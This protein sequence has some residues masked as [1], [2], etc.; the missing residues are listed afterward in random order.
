MPD[1]DFSDTRIFSIAFKVV[2]A[3][4]IILVIMAGPVSFVFGT[5]L[6]F[7]PMYQVIPYVEALA[8]LDAEH[9]LGITKVCDKVT[10]GSNNTC[11]FTTTNIDLFNDTIAIYDFR[12]IMLSPYPGAPVVHSAIN[13]AYNSQFAIVS[14]TNSSGLTTCA[15]G[16]IPIPTA[17]QAICNVGHGDRV[18]VH[19]T[20]FK[21]NAKGTFP[22]S[23][24]VEWVDLCDAPNTQACDPVNHAVSAAG[25]ATTVI[26]PSVSIVKTASPTK[27]TAGTNVTYTYKVTNTGNIR[28]NNCAVTDNV[29]GPIGS[30]QSP[31]APGA[32]ATLN[33]TAIVSANVT[34]TGTVTCNHQLGQVSNSSSATVRVIHPAI[35]VVKTCDSV[36]PQAPG[37]ITWH[38]NVTNIGDVSLTVTLND[39]SSHTFP[40]PFSLI[41]GERRSFNFTDSNLAAGTY[42]D[43]VTAVG[44]YQLGEVS[45]TDTASCVISNTTTTTI[46]TKTADRTTAKPGD[47]I[48]YTVTEHNNGPAAISNVT[49]IDSFNGTLTVAS[50][51]SNNPGIL[52]SGETWTFQTYTRHVTQ[53]DCNKTLHN[54]VTAT[55]TMIGDGP[56]PKETAQFDVSVVCPPIGGEILGTNTSALLVAAVLSNAM[57]M[58]PTLVGVAGAAILTALGLR[59]RNSE[60]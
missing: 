4:A 54:N 14:I 13:P 21:M 41:P 37:T 35:D 51:D 56:A 6:V 1:N 8:P 12:D 25:S 60:D 11:F 15:V 53:L 24:E 19:E 43:T 17:G 40:P 20:S 9:G 7:S 50:G 39:T 57:W 59:R 18:R 38:V 42:N 23:A 26:S 36:T 5:P 33:K 30:T 32:S 55:G 27:V 44:K 29:Y 45:D 34:N 46:L 16:P 2:S 3:T 52:D 28:L 48:T 47:T 31:L 58:I 22:D 49:V 10:V